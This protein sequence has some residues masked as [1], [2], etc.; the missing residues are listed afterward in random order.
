MRESILNDSVIK[1]HNW[2]R[3]QRDRMNTDLFLL[4]NPS[5]VLKF[6]TYQK[7]KMYHNR[8]IYAVIPSVSRLWVYINELS[9]RI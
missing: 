5:I 3:Y 2:Y 7:M 4:K 1:I 6:T 8:E 9:P